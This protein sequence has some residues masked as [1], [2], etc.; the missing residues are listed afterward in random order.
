MGHILKD[1]Y[2]VKQALKFNEKD[3]PD[4]KTKHRYDDL[5]DGYEFFERLLIEHRL[6]CAEGDVA[7]MMMKALERETGIDVV[8]QEELILGLR[9]GN[10]DTITAVLKALRC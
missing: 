1:M 8:T 9:T 3:M 2:S 6:F 5:A 10:R 4:D 7:A